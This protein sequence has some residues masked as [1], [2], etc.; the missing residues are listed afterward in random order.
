M[1]R[2]EAIEALRQPKDATPREAKVSEVL[3]GL[4]DILIAHGLADDVEALREFD[5]ERIDQAGTFVLGSLEGAIDGELYVLRW[6]ASPD[7]GVRLPSQDI[8]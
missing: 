4:D 3:A 1:T 7:V 2:T 8:D 5:V 6:L